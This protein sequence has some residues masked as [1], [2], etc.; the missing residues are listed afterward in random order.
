MDNKINILGVNTN[1]ITIPRLHDKISKYIDSQKKALVLNVNIH[2][3]NIAR[4][5]TEF[6]K[7]LNSSSIVFCDGYGVKLGAWL[8]NK[9]I[10]KVIS[11]GEWIWDLCE[12]CSRLDY[13]LFILGGY[14]GDSEKAAERLKRKYSSLNISGTHDGY[15]KKN[16]KESNLVLKKINSTN[17][18]IL[19]CSFGMPLQEKWLDQNYKS[20]ITTKVVI[21]YWFSMAI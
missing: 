9:N 21:R 6:R 5:D 4:I 19:L 10:P 12:L 8:L 1:R 7:I 14:P 2:A 13:R 18:D 17:P 15:F 3:I 20:T 16:G 11:Y